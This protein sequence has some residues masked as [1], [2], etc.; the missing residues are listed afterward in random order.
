MLSISIAAKQ[1]CLAILIMFC[2]CNRTFAQADEGVP[3][4]L[5]IELERTVE[6]A[7]EE[8]SDDPEFLDEL[9]RYRHKPINLY[10]ATADLLT[11]L[12]GITLQDAVVILTFVDSL[13][14]V[15]FDQFEAI[16]TLSESQRST[17]SSYTTLVRP[18]SEFD[19]PSLPLQ[20]AVRSRWVRD[21]Q[22]RRGYGDDLLRRV[23]R[24]DPAT[25]DSLGVDTISIG[26]SYIGSHDALMTQ[27]NVEYGGHELNLTVEKDA[28]EPL[29]FSDTLTRSY[30]RYELVDP[31]QPV[32]DV[33][34]R[35]GTF[36]SGSGAVTI[37]ATRI[38]L[39]DF[40]AEYGQGLALWSSFGG[41]KG[42]DVVD[43]PYKA[44]RGIVPYR[45][46]G[47]VAFFRGGA[48]TFNEA[49]RTRKGFSGSIFGSYRS[50]D[51]L[52]DQV[53]DAGGDTLSE[54]ITSIGTDGYHRTRTELRRSGGLDER[55]VAASA[56]YGFPAG[57][58][59]ITGYD[60]R[61]SSPIQPN[62]PYDFFGQHLQLFS[63][64][65]RYLF[66][67]FYLFAETVRD[68][69][70][71]IGAITGIGGSFDNTKFVI[72]GRS[73]D[74]GFYTPHGVGFGE[75]PR[76]QQ[77]EHGIYIGVKVPVIPQGIFSAY[78]D[79]YRFPQQSYFVPF[80]ING[81]DGM[82][83]FDWSL[84]PRFSISCRLKQEVK[85]DALTIEEGFGRE[86]RALFDKTTVSGRVEAGYTSVGGRVQLRTRFERKYVGY[87]SLRPAANGILTFLDLRWRPSTLLS[88]G[89][90]I[91]FF[92]G[93]NFDAAI[94]E[95]EQDVPGRFSNLALYNQ[96]QRLYLFAR[97]QPT[98][99][100]TITA[101]YGETWYR[102]QNIISEGSLQEIRG[103]LN[104]SLTVQ[105]DMRF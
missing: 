58:I 34:H 15:E 14:P 78:F 11:R 45:S 1:G 8:G 100:G 68:N 36:I 89:G 41:N 18:M 84:S 60:A 92:N 25:G 17:L 13:N 52:F 16:P 91:A 90:R 44:G 70:G 67:E 35:L 57:H 20:I 72:A 63:I 28:G 65:G 93:D 33:E 26:P 55:V 5:E 22:P 38:I 61:Y 103:Q 82:L 24:R 6:A 50:F 75:S 104:N 10:T 51:A 56:R 4:G 83:Q 7:T 98:E 49:G 2:L 21:L 31:A 95:Y 69:S 76:E 62:L 48:I 74:A 66:G 3:D 37:G 73:V 77:N 43:A 79:L 23:I 47:E 27:I 53:I 88:F 96:G 81:A 101:K 40:T 80:P 42:G 54:V 29:A 39:G 19:H 85:G 59:G 71:K 32:G 86:H 87:A 9:E 94:Y 12:P 30:T 99:W 102:N 64:D 46:T 97:W 105:I